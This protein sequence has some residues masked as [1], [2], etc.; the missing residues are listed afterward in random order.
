MRSGVCGNVAKLSP[1]IRN[2]FQC[3][4][5]ERLSGTAN[6]AEEAILP[7]TERQVIFMVAIVTVMPALLALLTAPASGEESGIPR[8]ALPATGLALESPVRAGRFYDVVGRYFEMGLK[9][10]F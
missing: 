8:F 9:A 4:V 2:R 6:L 10:K 7:A 3:Q 1:G 5:N